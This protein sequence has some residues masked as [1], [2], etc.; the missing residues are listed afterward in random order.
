MFLH[1]SVQIGNLRSQMITPDPVSID[2]G[3][4][5]SA[6][7]PTPPDM[8]NTTTKEA[9]EPSK[10]A[11]TTAKV[12]KKSLKPE[13]YLPVQDLPVEL[14]RTDDDLTKC[15]ICFILF[16]DNE[17]EHDIMKHMKKHNDKVK[18]FNKL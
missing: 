15:R 5:S 10:P 6:R 17:T 8:D 14:V 3:R 7:T 12:P 18:N 13:T 1:F 16:E 4:F 2:S 9:A 11:M